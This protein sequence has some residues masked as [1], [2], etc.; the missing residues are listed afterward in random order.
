VDAREQATKAALVQAQQES[1]SWRESAAIWTKRYYD[2]LLP[3]L[4]RAEARIVSLVEALREIRELRTKLKLV[5]Y[6]DQGETER[7]DIL[8]DSLLAQSVPDVTKIK[9]QWQAEALL[10][11]AKVA[12]ERAANCDTEFCTMWMNRA[13]WLRSAADVAHPGPAVPNTEIRRRET[14]SKLKILG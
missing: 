14:T 9:A 12:D 11:L 2:E 8:I 5:H 6:W 10:E 13:T 1:E 3:E 7:F 4:R